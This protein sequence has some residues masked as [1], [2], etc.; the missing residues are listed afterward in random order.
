MGALLGP[1]GG[2]LELVGASS[3]E[4]SAPPSSSFTR[5]L[6]GVV[7][8]Q[9][10]PLARRVWEATV[11]TAKPEQ[12]HVLSQL[13]TGLLG[14]GPWVWYDELSQVTNLLTPAASML[15]PGTWV[16]DGASV[17]G[18]GVTEDGTAYFRSVVATPEATVR[19]GAPEG[20]VPVPFETVVTASVYVT[21][22]S[23][24]GGTVAI[25]QV[26][27]EGATVDAPR[28]LDVEP[29]TVGARVHAT[30]TTS[31]RTVALRITATGS[32]MLAL[33]AVTLSDTPLPWATGRGCLAASLYLPGEDVQLALTTDTDWG[34]RSGYSMTITELG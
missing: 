25:E 15:H 13:G 26:D 18:A 16:G 5:S 8:E 21:A 1:V 2:L 19:I 11:G 20:L 30:L 24:T 29:G 33:P 9:R 6:S 17:G 7:R 32:L 34:R 27:P 10:G 31:M 28:V 14:P 3:S 4:V 22:Y 23:A 12:W